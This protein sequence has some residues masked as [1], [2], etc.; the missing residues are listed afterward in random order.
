MSEQLRNR[1]NLATL[2]LLAG[3]LVVGAE[4]VGVS[5]VDS[6]HVYSQQRGEDALYLLGIDAEIAGAV[7]IV[8]AGKL[9]HDAHND[10]NQ[11]SQ[12]RLMAEYRVSQPMQPPELPQ[13]PTQQ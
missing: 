3:T 1:K 13:P 6:S 4:A 7:G 8:R 11:R 9:L 10:R 5:L 12:Q 2:A